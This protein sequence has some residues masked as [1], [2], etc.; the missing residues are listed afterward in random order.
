MTDSEFIVGNVYDKYG[1][2][3]PVARL[4]MA[5]F[6]EAVTDL[7]R[8]VGP[9]SVLEVGCG[10]GHLAAHLLSSGGRPTRFVATDL[11][12]ARVAP[13]LDPLLEFQEVSAYALPFADR[14][15]ELVLCC[16]V[17]EHLDHPDR[18]L[19]ELSRVAG[20]NVIVSTPREPLWRALNMARGKYWRDLGNTPGHVQHFSARGL[21]R[22][23]AP[24]LRVLQRRAPVPWTVLLTEPRR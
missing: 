12:L 24:H 6:L 20:R 9:A 1:T 7:Y 16:E 15:F 3:N 22:R 8:E 18:A 14:E 10:E 11:S 19:R 17:L 5:G 13:G 4:L 2:R 21:E 23:V